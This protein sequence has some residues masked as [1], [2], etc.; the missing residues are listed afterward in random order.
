ME[1]VFG[2][3]QATIKSISGVY[4]SEIENNEEFQKAREPGRPV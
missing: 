2:R 3:Y 1:K 4:S